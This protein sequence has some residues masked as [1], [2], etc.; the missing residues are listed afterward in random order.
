[1]EATQHVNA[2]LLAILA[3]VA[4]LMGGLAITSRKRWNKTALS[5]CLAIGAG[6]ILALSLLKLIPLAF[7]YSTAAPLYLLLGYFIVHFAEHGL[8]PHLHF[9]EETHR[10]K[11]VRPVVGIAA[12]AGLAVHALFDGVTMAS[13]FTIDFSLGLIIFVALL[14]HK[15]PE[16]F[17]VATIFLASGRSRRAALLAAGMLG[18]FTLLGY[19]LLFGLRQPIAIFLPISAGATLYIAA[20][21]LIPAVNEERGIR[22]SLCVFA[23]VCLFYLADTLVAA[24]AF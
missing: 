5:S 16:G 6:F 24:H 10:E 20:S 18:A 23:G 7:E 3:G 4:N 14:L 21:D 15:I 22:M 1:M 13:G 9:G 8:S 19:V 12:F 11:M 17:T 2:A